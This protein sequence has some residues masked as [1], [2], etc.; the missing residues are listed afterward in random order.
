MTRDEI[1][2]KGKSIALP[3]IGTGLGGIIA[4]VCLY[5]VVNIFPAM[6]LGW[7]ARETAAK[8]LAVQLEA[9]RTGNIRLETRLV[10]IEKQLERNT[11][12]R[13]TSIDELVYAME[14]E[15]AIQAVFPEFEMPIPKK[16][17]FPGPAMP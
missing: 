12:N 6:G 2:E 8:D 3:A 9:L 17:D 4:M 14:I 5:L 16:L 7:E 15:D 1:A 11:A 10:G 13:W